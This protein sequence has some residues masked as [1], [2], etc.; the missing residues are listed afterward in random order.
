MLHAL[1][2][3]GILFMPPAKHAIGKFIL[4][5]IFQRQPSA[6]RVCVQTRPIDTYLIIS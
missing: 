4:G 5:K 2:C 6:N 1:R 3:I